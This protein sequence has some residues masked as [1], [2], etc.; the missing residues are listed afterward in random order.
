MSAGK[1]TVQSSGGAKEVISA[2]LLEVPGAVGTAS[3]LSEVDDWLRSLPMI[4]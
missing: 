1:V 3:S 4:I 2:S